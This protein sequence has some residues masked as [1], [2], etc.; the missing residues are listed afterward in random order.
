MN[1]FKKI[2]V[3]GGYGFIG[4]AL[5]RKLL[6]NTKADIF[7]LDKF[8]LVSDDQSVLN[9]VEQN[10]IFRNRYKFF[11]VDIC[12][13]ELLKSIIE[14]I[15][16]DLIFHLA[17]ESHVD[18]SII[19]PSQFVQ[20]NI[21]GTYNL[22]EI[23]RNYLSK[24]NIDYF[25]LLH[26]STDEVFGSLGDLGKFSES[27][28]YDPK[29]PYSA[30]KASSDHLVRAWRNTYNLPFI[31]TNCSNNFGEWQFPEKLIPLSIQKIINGEKIP[32]YGNGLQ[33]RDW[34]Y[35]EDH[36]DALLTISEK[37]KI[38]EDYCIGGNCE[39][40]N[41]E[42]IKKISDTINQIS[43][44][45]HSFADTIK[46]VEDRP[47]HDT[48]YAIDFTKIKKEIGWE[49]SQKFTLALGKT[50]EWYLNNQDWSKRVLQKANY[51]TQRIGLLD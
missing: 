21:I 12:E 22:I 27:T 24:S 4:S 8:G 43:N 50:V 42:L 40:K 32:I 11:K 23:T 44:Y 25:K 7:N 30:T 31:V 34:L 20:S 46:Y 29:S 41:I 47:G 37:G 45:K 36:V 3:T 19:N 2:L 51:G 5:I 18:R 49:P 14:D 28:P 35:V 38:N 48:R 9:I 16:P 15:K 1:N 6:I 39:I 17:A 10:K 13:F 33:I 26:I